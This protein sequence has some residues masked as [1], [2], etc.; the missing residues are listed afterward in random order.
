MGQTRMVRG[1]LRWPQFSTCKMRSHN[2]RMG[3]EKRLL[4]NAEPECYAIVSDGIDIRT[5]C[6]GNSGI[7]PLPL[8]HCLLRILPKQQ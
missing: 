6:S 3:T 4:V 2:Q 8:I 1:G 7:P 5:A